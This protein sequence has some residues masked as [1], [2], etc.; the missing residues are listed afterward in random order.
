MQLRFHVGQIKRPR[1][2]AL[3]EAAVPATP[4][5]GGGR[6][7][8]GEA[9]LAKGV[10]TTAR[11]ERLVRPFRLI[12]SSA[13]RRFASPVPAIA[14]V[15]CGAWQESSTGDALHKMIL[16]LDGQ[17]DI[18]G[19]SGG[20]LVIPN[21]IIFI[22]AD[23]PFNLRTAGKTRTMVAYLDPGDS[24]WHHHGCWV[25]RANGL[26]H[27]MFAYM[28]RLYGAEGGETDSM[29]Q[30]FR[31][32]SLLCRDW[33]SNPRILWLP[34]AKSEATRRFIS[35]VRDHLPSVTVA[36][37]CRECDLPQRTMQRI[38]RQEFGH[39][40]R[41]LISEVRMMRAMELLAKGDLSVEAAAHA[42]GFNSVGSFTAA[43]SLRVGL[44]PGEFKQRNRAA[45]RAC[46]ES[47]DPR[48]AKV[49]AA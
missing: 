3:T 9:I 21:H 34:A 46:L 37:A 1:G 31:T 23:R 4:G 16:V 33:F 18:E 24:E 47:T 49:A 35:H 10:T 39:G 2:G 43:F 26:A 44:S 48:G 38:S 30:M 25:T 7:G 36:S 13:G 14:L 8:Q 17:I 27:E 15:Q 11:L 22:P 28:L 19:P 6:Y 40:L 32:L 12:S 5:R 45:L 20:W 29:R 41:T 42:V